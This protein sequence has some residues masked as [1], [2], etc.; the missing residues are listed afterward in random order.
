[1]Q[2]AKKK[3]FGVLG[4]GLVTALTV[5]ANCLPAPEASAVSS[6]SGVKIEVTVRSDQSQVSITA[7]KDGAITT[8]PNITFQTAYNQIAGLNY[9]LEYV[10][11]GQTHTV[12]LGNFV[13]PDPTN[14]GLADVAIDL[15][16]YGG[17]FGE[18]IFRVSST[19]AG[20]VSDSVSFTY[21]SIAPVDPTNPDPSKPSD[22][23][24]PPAK[25]EN[26]DPIITMAITDDICYLSF[27]AYAKTTGAALFNPDFV[28]TVPT[29]RPANNVVSVTLPFA[30]NNAAADDYTVMVTPLGCA[31]DRPQ[32]SDP[33]E[34]II[35]S[36]T[37]PAD[38]SKPVVPT[39]DV[40]D[41][42]SITIA[43][44]T[45][46]RADYLITGLAVFGSATIVGLFLLS[47]KKKNDRR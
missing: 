32:I 23:D 11:N 17:G 20:S 8:S 3:L 7:P 40:P 28:Y 6:D 2:K 21:S 5:A 24:Q 10:R 38:P 26:N 45:L 13:A 27:Q 19:G 36:Y 35:G 16:R 37:P 4:L 47:R 34:I 43:G 42:G 31:A 29:P 41:T 46:S 30:A 14:P 39:P 15:S 12:D 1:M 33:I 9:T 18:Y 44:I 22:P 25:E